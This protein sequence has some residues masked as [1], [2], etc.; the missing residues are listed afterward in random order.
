MPQAAAAVVLLSLVFQTQTPVATTRPDFNGRWA[1][2]APAPAQPGQG[3]QGAAGAP[4]GRAGGPGAQA[5]SAGSGWLTP[6]T[7]TQTANE[8][9]VEYSFF[10]RGDMQPPL[11]HVFALDGSER[12]AT[13]NLGRGPQLQVT[14]ASW[15]AD[16]LVLKTVHSFTDPMTGK[17]MTV[18]V[19]QTLSLENATTLIVETVRGPALGGQAT[20][21]KSTYQKQ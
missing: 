5:V 18:D 19:K 14:S 15:A 2:V 12:Q 8:L 13:M 4:G 21:A 3:R 20:S 9:T 1:D 7:I 11:K 10:S 6:F 17:P 16:K